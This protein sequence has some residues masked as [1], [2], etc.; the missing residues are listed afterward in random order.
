MK[1]IQYKGKNYDAKKKG[2]LQEQKPCIRPWQGDPEQSGVVLRWE[3]VNSSTGS[4]KKGMWVGRGTGRRWDY[5]LL[6]FSV[7]FFSKMWKWEL[8]RGCCRSEQTG[9]AWKSFQR[10]GKKT[11]QNLKSMV[12]SWVLFGNENVQEWK[13]IESGNRG[14]TRDQR[15]RD[16]LSWREV[17]WVHT[18]ISKWAHRETQTLG[19]TWLPSSLPFLHFLQNTG[20][21]RVPLAL[22][23]K[24]AGTAEG[25]KQEG[26]CAYAAQTGRKPLSSGSVKSPAWSRSH[27]RALYSPL[28][29]DLWGEIQRGQGF[30]KLYFIWGVCMC[31]CLLYSSL[32]KGM[33]SNGNA[34]ETK[35]D[36][37]SDLMEKQ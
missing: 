27:Q 31:V 24:V 12:I 23:P 9:E 22:P 4:K 13:T 15:D 11:D 5:S 35:T 34:M 37:V 17:G 36:V 30:S 19:K 2:G 29:K 18:K 6:F 7:L 3:Q 33:L 16:K 20:L 10:V 21:I 26:N 32:N 1:I 28:P 8:V 25:S 14:D